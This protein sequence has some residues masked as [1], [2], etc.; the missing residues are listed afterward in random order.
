M[1][2][3]RKGETVHKVAGFVTRG[4]GAQR[5]LLVFRHPAGGLQLPA[6]TVEVGE[7][8][9]AAVLREVEEETGLTGN[10][11][12]GHLGSHAES[13]RP[14][15]RMICRATPLYA[16]PRETASTLS[17]P[18]V[19]G[20]SMRIATRGWGCRLLQD[21][22]QDAA[23]AGYLRVG[24]DLIDST[25]GDWR[26]VATVAGWV[27]AD[28]L[29]ADVRRHL[30]HLEATAPTLDRWLHHGDVPGCE[31]AWKRLDGE[32]GLVSGQS[33]WL[34]RIRPLLK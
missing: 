24:F 32:V 9:E 13:W 34:A 26:I 11:L 6:G 20:L 29:T 23:E 30:F 15:G 33:E 22:G 7:T 16:E 19:A 4:R 8:I 31:L 27:P 1:D 2:P 17:I 3:K 18:V 5:E 12:M 21:G 10:R 28:A 14:D 25:G